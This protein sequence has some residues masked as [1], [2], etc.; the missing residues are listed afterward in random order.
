Q[1]DGAVCIS[2]AVAEEYRAWLQ[3]AGVRTSAEYSIKHFHLGADIQQ[4]APSQGLS[5]QDSA[6]LE[7]LAGKQNFLMVGTVEPRKAHQLVLDA[8]EELWKDGTTVNLVVVGKRG[9]LVDALAERMQ[10]HPQQ[11]KRLFWLAGTSD[12]MLE[13]IYAVSTCLIFASEGE[14]FGLPLIEAAQHGLPVIA[15]DLPVFR[16][17]AGSNAYYFSAT[18]ARELAQAVNDW[19]ALFA[20]NQHP[21]SSGMPRLTWKESTAQLVSAMDLQA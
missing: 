19:A 20:A 12:E 11:G 21:K 7:Q 2:N 8:F 15:R 10:Q 16:E 1:M 6:L 3:S 17:V 14:G 9:W 18:A 13:K 4:S 5:A